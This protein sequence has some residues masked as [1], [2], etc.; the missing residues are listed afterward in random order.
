MIGFVCLSVSSLNQQLTKGLRLSAYFQLTYCFAVNLKWGIILSINHVLKLSVFLDCLYI[1]CAL[2]L[3][4]SL[5]FICLIRK[6]L[7]LSKLNTGNYDENSVS[8]R[9]RER[10]S[11]LNES[12]WQKADFFNVMRDEWWRRHSAFHN[13]VVTLIDVKLWIPNGLRQKANYLT[14]SET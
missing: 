1:A 9:G 2:I 5:I 11:V 6:F 7:R 8:G 14:Q 12:N 13:L 10:W 3:V 4:Y